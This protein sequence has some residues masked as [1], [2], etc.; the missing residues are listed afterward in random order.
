[1][2]SIALIV[3]LGNDAVTD[4]DGGG[5]GLYAP[6]GVAP[7]KVVAPQPNRLLAFQI[8]PKSFHAFQTNATERNSITQ[9]FHTPLAW[10]HRRYGHL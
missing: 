4:A 3:Y 6:R 9:W 7:A 2:R 1:M 5:T 10:S 8:S